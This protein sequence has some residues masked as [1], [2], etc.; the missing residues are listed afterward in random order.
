MFNKKKNPRAID[1]DFLAKSMNQ[2]P[3]EYGKAY[4]CAFF[5]RDDAAEIIAGAN[6]CVIYGVLYTSY[7]QDF[8]RTGSV[9]G[10][11]CILMRKAL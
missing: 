1:I 9:K 4:P 11:R 7:G 6:D 5:I 3:P 8:K 10:S 2:G